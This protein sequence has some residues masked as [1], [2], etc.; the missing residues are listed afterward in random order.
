[1]ST[2]CRKITVTMV[3]NAI[4]RTS[5]PVQTGFSV[6][7]GAGGSGATMGGGN[8]SAAIEVDGCGSAFD[9]GGLNC[10]ASGDDKQIL[11]DPF[12][13]GQF[14]ESMVNIRTDP[15]RIHETLRC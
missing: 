12:R 10:G 14:S 15:A 7:L 13:Y 5:Q 6:D 11:F 8:E 9:G 4:W 1:M 3:R 2:S